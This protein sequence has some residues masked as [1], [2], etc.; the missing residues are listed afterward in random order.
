MICAIFSYG[1]SVGVTIDPRQSGECGKNADCTSGLCIGSQ[2]IEPTI[3]CA[4]KCKNTDK[5][6]QRYQCADT[7]S[8][9]DGC[10]IDQMKNSDGYC[11]QKKCSNNSDCNSNACFEGRCV[12]CKAD[13][14][15]KDDFVCYKDMEKYILGGEEKYRAFSCEL[16][17]YRCKVDS[18]CGLS[19]CIVERTVVQHP[20]YSDALLHFEAGTCVFREDTY[21]KKS[22]EVYSTHGANVI[23][24]GPAAIVLIEPRTNKVVVS[25]VTPDYSIGDFEADGRCIKL[26]DKNGEFI[27]MTKCHFEGLVLVDNEKYGKIACYGY[28]KWLEPLKP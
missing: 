2:C 22:C 25:A 24:N 10:K 21:V 26:L 9:P 6:C 28:R 12:G 27:D 17:R 15:C 14:N 19:K 13:S 18:D 7:S 5:T 11:V 3:E 8:I 1:C 16:P 20:N 23:F 4:F